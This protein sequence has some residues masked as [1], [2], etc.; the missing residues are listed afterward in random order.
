MANKQPE[1]HSG[2]VHLRLYRLVLAMRN[3]G[4]RGFPVSAVDQS[5]HRT[6]IR[7]LVN[8]GWFKAQRSKRHV[9]AYLG[10]ARYDERVRTHDSTGENSTL[11]P[12]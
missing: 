11:T 3:Y 10:H 7:V 12:A 8:S 1:R 6:N 5:P 9:N 4:K 2:L